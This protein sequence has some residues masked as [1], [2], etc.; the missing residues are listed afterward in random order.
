MKLNLSKEERCG[1]RWVEA[2][3]TYPTS[4]EDI[5]N[6]VNWLCDVCDTDWRVRIG[7][8]RPAP[9]YPDG[10]LIT[11]MA[12]VLDYHYR[13]DARREQKATIYD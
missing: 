11:T 12:D 3:Q 6:T 1:D 8:Q 13:L 7:I 4:A 10:R 2:Y 9:R 5:L